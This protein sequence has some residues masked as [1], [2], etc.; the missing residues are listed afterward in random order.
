MCR[1]AAGDRPVEFRQSNI[2][3]ELVD[4]IHEAIDARP[5]AS[6]SIRPPSPS[7]PI[8]ILDALKMFPG[9]I[10]ELHICNIHRREPDLP[11]LAGLDG[12]HGGDRRPRPAGYPWRCGHSPR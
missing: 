9:P 3:G 10:I 2:E 12:G 8:A 4:W 7:P 1:A 6:S 5:P 11:P